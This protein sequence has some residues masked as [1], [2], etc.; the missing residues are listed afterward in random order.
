MT[1][2]KTLR[3]STSGDGGGGEVG[4]I[5]GG[6]RM[7]V[8]HRIEEDDLDGGGVINLDNIPEAPPPEASGPSGAPTTKSPSTRRRGKRKSP[9]PPPSTDDGAGEEEGGSDNDSD[10]DPF[11][12]PLKRL[13]KTAM[14]ASAKQT[15][16]IRDEDGDADPDWSENGEDEPEED[17]KK[18]SLRTEFEGF[19]IYSRILC[20]VV[21]RR[22]PVNVGRAPAA[23]TPSTARQMD[24][25]N[26]R[27][28]SGNQIMENWIAM[29]QAVKEGDEED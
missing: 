8:Q 9:D 16:T 22:G 7:Q 11:E 12:P 18:L 15:I 25:L 27:T 28:R 6:A 13:R 29:S 21:K 23:S 26:P 4:G 2:R 5:T 3:S 19:S 17:K 14:S 10:S 1:K 24:S 20:L